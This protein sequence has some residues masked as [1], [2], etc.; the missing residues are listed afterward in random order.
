MNIAYGI[1]LTNEHSTKQIFA[2]TLSICTA[3]KYLHKR[4]NQIFI[5]TNQRKTV[6]SHIE[7]DLP[8][9]I[10]DKITIIPSNEFVDR[11]YSLCGNDGA[12][13]YLTAGIFYRIQ[14]LCEIDDLLYVDNDVIFT[15]SKFKL[16]KFSKGKLVKTDFDSSCILYSRTRLN[17]KDV[18]YYLTYNKKHIATLQYP[19]ECII[20]DGF[21][22]LEKRYKYIGVYH[23]GNT[24][25]FEHNVLNMSLYYS[26]MKYIKKV[27]KIEPGV[28]E[29]FYRSTRYSLIM[30]NLGD[31]KC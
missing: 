6:E 18:I 2:C 16:P 3:Y 30:D 10:I 8:K 15:S 14:A 7:S 24:E 21:G 23:F 4:I 20:H 19:D 9:E 5:Y 17:Y 26:L 11:I 29:T 25:Y 13:K 27:D 12:H 1:Y 28:F 22:H 31:T